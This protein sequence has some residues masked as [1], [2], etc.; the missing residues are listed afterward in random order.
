[1]FDRERFFPLSSRMIS[2][3]VVLVLVV[4][5]APSIAQS[6]AEVATEAT[7]AK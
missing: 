7:E 4:G 5:V 3:F 1:M 6:E 2:L